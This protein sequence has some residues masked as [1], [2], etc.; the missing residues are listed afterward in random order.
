MTKDDSVRLAKLRE[1]LENLKRNKIV[2]N[3]RLRTWL[4]EVGYKHYV[5]NWERDRWYKVVLLEKPSELVE[6]EEMLRVATLIYSKAESARAKGRKSARKLYDQAQSAFE[7]AL[8]R[9]GDL[10]GQDQSLTNWLDRPCDFGVDGDLGLSPTQVPRVITSRSLENRSGGVSSMV[11]SKRQCKIRSV[12]SAIETILNPPPETG[13]EDITK[14]L[15]R[16]KAAMR[17]R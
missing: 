8:E 12:E 4:G 11:E 1:L 5:D 7:K 17:K 6:Y 9:L 3:R 13:D 15:E 14:K 16:L 10:V 2:Q